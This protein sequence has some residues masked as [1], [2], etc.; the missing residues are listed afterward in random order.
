VPASHENAIDDL[1]GKPLDAFTAARDALARELRKDGEKAVANRVKEL[2]KPTIS[3]WAINQLV[4]RER[5]QIR[6][7][8]VAGE[9]LRSAHADLLGGGRPADVR[10]AADAERK[11]ISHL[12]SSAAEILSEA[13]HS[14]SESALERVA[15]TLR[16]AAVDEEGRAALERGRLTRDLDP[17]GFGPLELAAKPRDSKVGRRG[18]EANRR[19]RE[20]R[21]ALQDELKALRAELRELGKAVTD[22][23]GN[24]ATA[25]RN[26]RAAEKEAGSAQEK[27]DRAERRLQEAESALAQLRPRR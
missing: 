20:R 17:T 11:A 12:V 15:T 9:K 3:A 23:D 1:Y 21:Q 24:V 2:R 18:D 26:L 16:A 10:E 7:L 19:A 14:A 22:A 6:S 25:E 8:L 5:M 13:G 4:R 27:Y